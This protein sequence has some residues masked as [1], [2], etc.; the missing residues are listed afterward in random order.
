MTR[1]AGRTSAIA[2]SR[3]GVAVIV[4]GSA[5]PNSA[6]AVVPGSRAARARAVPSAATCAAVTPGRMRAM[7]PK[8]CSEIRVAAVAVYR[9]DVGGDPRLRFAVGE[10]E[11]GRHHADHRVGPFIEPD[12]AAKDVGTPAEAA[13]P[14]CVRQDDGV[15]LRPPR[16]AASKTR[17]MS[18]RASQHRE[19]GRR[20]PAET[21]SLG[22]AR[23]R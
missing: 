14:E 1:M 5:L 15:G 16:P 2:T 20:Q 3:A 11:R 19:D 4:G 12:G 22:L 7:A 23:H 17:P 8:I 9:R 13:L 6:S 21:D 10:R 18:A